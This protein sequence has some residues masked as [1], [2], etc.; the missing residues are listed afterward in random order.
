MHH[1]ILASEPL[2]RF[3]AGAEGKGTHQTTNTILASCCNRLLVNEGTSSH[4]PPKSQLTIADTGNESYDKGSR[5][6]AYVI[7]V[8]TIKGDYTFELVRF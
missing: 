8:I 6:L 7:K 3:P 4:Q 1:C 2:A 5:I